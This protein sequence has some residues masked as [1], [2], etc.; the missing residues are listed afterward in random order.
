MPELMGKVL[1]FGGGE[2]VIPSANLYFF[3]FDNSKF[4]KSF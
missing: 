2:S 1:S 4:I 3:L